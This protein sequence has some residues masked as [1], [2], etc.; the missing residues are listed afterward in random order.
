MFMNLLSSRSPNTD[1]KPAEFQ[2]DD[3]YSVPGEIFEILEIKYNWVYH[4]GK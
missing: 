4:L 2:I 3:T 1:D